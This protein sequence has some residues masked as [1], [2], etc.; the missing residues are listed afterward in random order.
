M[1]FA[2]SEWSDDGTSRGAWRSSGVLQ[3][4]SAILPVSC[5]FWITFYLSHA[6]FRLFGLRAHFTK[7]REARSL[8]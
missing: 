2:C 1:R 4:P 5:S 7:V 3:L 8:R 6:T